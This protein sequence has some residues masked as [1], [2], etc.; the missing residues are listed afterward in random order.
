MSVP[1]PP[2]APDPAPCQVVPVTPLSGS[3]GMEVAVAADL[4]CISNR[5]AIPFS[6][7]LVTATVT[8]VT[9]AAPSGSVPVTGAVTATAWV[10]LVS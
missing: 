1:A 8:L 10:G 7:T 3:A 2:G 4:G 9:S 6:S 5:F